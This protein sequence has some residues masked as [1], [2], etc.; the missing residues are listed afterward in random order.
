VGFF[1]RLGK[2]WHAGL[3]GTNVEA[4]GPLFQAWGLM[5]IPG[6]K[7]VAKAF[8]NFSLRNLTFSTRYYGLALNESRHFVH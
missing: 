7:I 4:A 1:G 2:A 3:R 5:F 8:C 6:R